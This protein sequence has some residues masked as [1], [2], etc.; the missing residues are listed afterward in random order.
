MLTR[1]TWA[2]A[3][4]ALI[5]VAM[6]AVLAVS[7]VPFVSWAPGGTFDVLGERDGKPVISISGVPSYDAPGQLRVTTVSVTAAD[8]TLSF[9]EA[10]LA[11]LLPDREVLPREAVYPAGQSAEDIDAENASAMTSSQQD[12]IVAALR[13]ANIPVTARPMVSVIVSG[14]PSEKLLKPGDLVVKVDSDPVSTIEQVRKHIQEHKVGDSVVFSILRDREPMNVTVTTQASNT[15]PSGPV[16]G[17][18]WV[19]GYEYD[20]DI[21]INID[22]SVGGPSAGLIFAIGIYDH[23]SNQRIVDGRSIAGTGEIS[24]DGTVGAIGGIREKIAGA[25]SSGA[26]MFLVPAANCADVAGVT[27]SMKLVKVTSLSDAISSLRL[28]KTGDT[29]LP[30]CNG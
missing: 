13:Q 9:P 27:T 17:V 12:A 4:S 28:S 23:L 8:G 5:F 6:A 29:N 1:Q 18:G 14:G 2:A 24:T 21:T 22:P 11:D 7:P 3:I 16:V 10:L 26:T 25:Q 15:S 19:T 30:S 20:A